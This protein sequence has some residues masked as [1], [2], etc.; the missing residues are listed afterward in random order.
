MSDRVG[1]GVVGAGSIGI[2]AALMHLSLPDVQDK[3]YLAAVCDPVPGRAKAAAEKYGVLAAYESYEDLLGDPRVDAVTICSP[4]GLHYEQG[5][6]AIAAGKHIH[7]NKTMTTTTA[8]AD[9]LIAKARAKGVLI[10]ASP[11]MMLFPHNQRVRKLVLEGKLGKLAWAICGAAGVGEYHIK[12]S[13]RAGDDVLSNIDPSWYYCKPGGGPQYDVTV[14]CLHIL[15]GIVGPAKRVTAMS[16]LVIPEREFRGKKIRCDM[17]DN[18]LLLLDFGDAF[19]AYVYG[20]VTGRVTEGFQ[21][22]IYGTQGSVVGTTYGSIDLKLPHDLEPHHVGEHAKMGE[23]HVFED[24]MQLVDWIRE[25]K[26]SVANA[27]HARHVIEIIDAGYRAAETGQ[28]QVLRTTFDPLPLE[29]LHAV[30]IAAAPQ[31]S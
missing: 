28:T 20:A 21:P 23:R 27:E 6:Q 8:E 18:T 30:E 1:M 2:R 29:A 31:A 15:T 25:G 19:F 9:D 5:L 17:D 24:M 11:G 10:V 16:G 13:V 4:I 12:E 26:P 3:V 7:F 22:N 14:Y